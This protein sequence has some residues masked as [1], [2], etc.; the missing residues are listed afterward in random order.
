M[1]GG[2]FGLE[3]PALSNETAP[4]PFAGPNMQYFL[5]V[6]C[7][8]EALVG[9]HRPKAVW[10]PSYLCA[11]ML[12]PFLRSGVE[13]HYYLVDDRLCASAGWT[14]QIQAGD[15]VVAIHYFGFPQVSFP[16]QQVKSRGAIL[17]EDASQA[18]FLQQQFRES[19]CILYSPRKFLGV[20]DGGV[21]VSAGETGTESIPLKAPPQAWWQ[22]ALALTLKRRDFDRTGK[23]ADWYAL[24][25]QV[26]ANYPVGLY[27]S[28]ELARMLLAGA[29]DYATIRTRRREN[30][31]RLLEIAGEYAVFPELGPDTVPLGFPV[32][33]RPNIRDAVLRQ[34]HAAR[35]FAPLHWRLD[36]IVP[37]RFHLSHRLSKSMFTL[38]SDQRGTLDDM[39]RQA[40]EFRIIE[41]AARA[42]SQGTRSGAPSGPQETHALPGV[43]PET[44]GCAVDRARESSSRE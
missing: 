33:V 34:L 12:T 22:A 35:I 32:R 17:V 7:A 28:S 3:C 11:E 5:S 25:Q 19:A 10:L 14:G 23:P 20:P 21:M 42:L 31:A 6:R 18:L 2:V 43:L 13:I 30:Y 36:G 1:L 38:L 29:V 4:P 15:L 39:D 8:L 24:F 9:A 41:Q 44:A 26:D 37:A 40:R 27:R 16:A